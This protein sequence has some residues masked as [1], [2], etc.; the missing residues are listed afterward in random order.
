MTSEIIKRDEN[1]A[2]VGAGVSNDADKD[3]LMIRMDAV[4]NRVL[5]DISSVGVTS[6]TASQIARRDENHR[7]VCMAWNED[8]AELQEILTDS[9]GYILA[10]LVIE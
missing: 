10:D 9:N 5:C 7:P 4:S 2:T 3:V 1:R 6:A 8:D